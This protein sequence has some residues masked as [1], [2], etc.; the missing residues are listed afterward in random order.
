M[1]IYVCTYINTNLYILLYKQVFSATMWPR[2]KFLSFVCMYV[3]V[4]DYCCNISGFYKVHMSMF[5]SIY[6]GSDFALN[7]KSTHQSFTYISR[8]NMNLF[9]KKIVYMLKYN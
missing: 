2:C 8:K 3:G 7:H 6:R 1:R 9:R 4:F 5:A